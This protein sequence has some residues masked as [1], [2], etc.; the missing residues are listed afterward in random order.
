ML[1]HKEVSV[2]HLFDFYDLVHEKST[3][4]YVGCFLDDGARACNTN[5]PMAVTTPKLCGEACA[6]EYVGLFYI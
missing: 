3:L 6:G 4:S 5:K 2:T 1:T